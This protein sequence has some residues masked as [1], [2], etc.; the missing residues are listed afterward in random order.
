[1]LTASE[2]H[3]LSLRGLTYWRVNGKDLA[4][5]LKNIEQKKEQI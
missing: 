1:M 5:D 2:V 3:A 4:L